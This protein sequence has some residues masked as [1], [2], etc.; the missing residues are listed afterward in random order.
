M[1]FSRGLLALI[2]TLF[3]NASLSAQY[4]Y[5][6][7]LIFNPA[8]NAE[9]EKL[10]LELHQKTGIALRLVMVKELPNGMNIV[11]YEN[12]LM[13]DFDSPT[14][15]L[16]FSEMDSKVDILAHPASL[17]EYFDKKQILSPVASPVQAFTM[18]LFYNEGFDSF[19]EIASSYGGTIIPLLAQKAK[20]G[21]V[22]GKYSGSMF[23]GYADIA[24][25]IADSKGIV[26]ENAVGNANQNSILLVKVLFYGFILYGIF[27]YI[28]RKIYLRREKNE[29]K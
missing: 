29:S 23:N 11:E 27:L 6:D 16:T 4:L 18:A 2:L 10:G 9:V 12:E 19:K 22:L 14:I 5:K 28:K 3:F 26:L 25:Q 13:K 21:E 7:E 17:Y 24:E 20:E 1:K 15:L 8:F